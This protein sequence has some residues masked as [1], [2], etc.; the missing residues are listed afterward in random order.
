MVGALKSYSFIHNFFTSLPV[1]F[2]CISIYV[3]VCSYRKYTTAWT[4]LW[5]VGGERQNVRIILIMT[6]HQCSNSK[7]PQNRNISEKSVT[8]FQKMAG[9]KCCLKRMTISPLFLGTS[10][11]LYN[12]CRSQMLHFKT[13]GMERGAEKGHLVRAED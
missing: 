10:T 5:R 13:W 6:I 8:V 7:L 11:C 12:F 4:D 9:C 2:T 1:S 3:C